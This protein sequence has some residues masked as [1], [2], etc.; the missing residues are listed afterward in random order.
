MGKRDK[1]G[2]GDGR[3]LRK[4]KNKEY[5]E[6]EQPASH[7]PSTARQ[8]PGGA[9][10][11]AEGEG[12]SRVDSETVTYL[13]EVS[14]HLKTLMDDEERDLLIQNVLEEVAG[15]ELDI[16]TD[17]VTSRLIE[18]LLAGASMAQLMQFM[19]AFADE[20]TLYRLAGRCVAG[21]APPASR[22]MRLPARM[23]LHALLS[24][25]RTQGGRLHALPWSQYRIA[26]PHPARETPFLQRFRL[27]RR[28]KGAGSAGCARGGR[29]RGGR[30]RRA[31]GVTTK[32][33]SRCSAGPPA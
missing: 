26:A 14:T 27:T 20:D 31:A 9:F 12:G 7:A 17:A 22:P 10:G 3:K 24:R 11:Y 19:A 5:N 6:E 16:A 30:N 8:P 29:R 1:D 15:K 32:L 4:A 23:A 21:L 25:G 13:T 33:L 28:G 2:G 18:Q